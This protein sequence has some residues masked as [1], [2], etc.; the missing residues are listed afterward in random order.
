MVAWLTNLTAIPQLQLQ[1]LVLKQALVTHLYSTTCQGQNIWSV[2]CLSRG[3][4]CLSYREGHISYHSNKV[5]FLV[6]SKVQ[7]FG[8]QSRRKLLLTEAFYDASA[9][10][11]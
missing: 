4:L 6:K 7:N 2:M 10:S 1:R 3:I 8:I 11:K 5:V 9:F